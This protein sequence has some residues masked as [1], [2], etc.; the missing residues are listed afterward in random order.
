M[1]TLRTY[2][3]KA[4]KEEREEYTER[5]GS[6]VNQFTNKYTC[7][8]SLRRQTPSTERMLAMIDESGGEVTA[9]GLAYDFIIEPLLTLM[10]HEEKEEAPQAGL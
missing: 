6:S 2:W 10:A 7:R 5:V 4:S 9:E 1:G 8:N 3:L